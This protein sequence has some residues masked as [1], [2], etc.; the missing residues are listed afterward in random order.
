MTKSNS[1]SFWYSSDC[2]PGSAITGLSKTLL[3]IVSLYSNSNLNITLN[4]YILIWVDFGRFVLFIVT[5][6]NT[7]FNDYYIF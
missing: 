3:N 5:I 1:F 6:N 4:M 7:N 2:I